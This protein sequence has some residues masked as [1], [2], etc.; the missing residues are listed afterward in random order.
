MSLSSEFTNGTGG[1]KF[2]ATAP[3]GIGRL[4]RIPFY[5]ETD[6]GNADFQALV[7]GAAISNSSTTSPIITAGSTTQ[8]LN[9]SVLLKTPQISW[10]TL[11]LVGFE[12]AINSPLNPGGAHSGVGADRPGNQTSVANLLVKD[13][14]IGGGA[15]LFVH[16]DFG[17]SAI[18]S[19]QNESFA[20]LRDY[21]LVKSPNVAQVTVALFNNQAGVAPVAGNSYSAMSTQVVFSCNLVCEILQDDQYG[22]HIPGPYARKGAMVRRG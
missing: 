20:G 9:T 8:G 6:Q 19:S 2:V 16:E 1:L 5:L 4:I 7:P 17:N 11:R 21:P 3:P 10:A 15:N 14:Q 22:S 13:L 18:Y 12:C